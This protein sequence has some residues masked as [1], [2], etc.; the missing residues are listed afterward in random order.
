MSQLLDY[1]FNINAITCY[2]ST[3]S[4]NLFFAPPSLTLSSCHKGGLFSGFSGMVKSHKRHKDYKFK[5][6]EEY[7]P[8]FTI[9]IGP[10]GV[11]KTDVKVVYLCLKGL[12]D[13]C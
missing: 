4:E 12:C 2:H 13:K 5:W 6:L 1:R 3:E 8:Q 10:F 9:I 7:F 11:E